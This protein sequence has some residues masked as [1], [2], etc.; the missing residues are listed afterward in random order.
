MTMWFE[1]E[2]VITPLDAFATLP[3]WLRA[4]MDGPRIQRSL[5]QAV[6]ELTAG[7]LQLRSCTPQRL[8]AKDDQWLA[9]YQLDIATSGGETKDIVLVGNLYAPAVTAPAVPA[10]DVNAPFG[11]AGW[12]C[13][14]PDL[15]LL[16]RVEGADPALPALRDILDPSAAADLLQKVLIDAGYGSA[17]VASCRPDPVRYKPGSRCTVVVG[18]TYADSDGALPGPDPIVI[19]THQGDKGQT[20]WTAMTALWESPLREGDALT[21]AEPLAYDAERRLLFQGPIPE[22]QTLKVLVRDAITDGTPAALQLLREELA[23]TGRGLAALHHCGAS[24]GRTAT[25][26]EEV[27]EI[28]EVVSRLSVSVPQLQVAADPLLDR[29]D[30]LSAAFPAEQ[31]VPA[32]HDFRPA[33]VLLHAGSIGFIDFDGASMAEPALDLGRFRAKL[34]DIGISTLAY[35]EKPLT[36][37]PLSENLTLLDDLCDVFLDAYRELAP[38]STE[39]VLL[40]E[41]CDL[42]TGMLHAWTKVRLARID[43]RLT[44]LRHHLTAVN[45]LAE[46]R[47]VAEGEPSRRLEAGAVL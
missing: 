20:A 31:S 14:L 18:V 41:T 38:V 39:R 9:R 42:L 15:R 24:Y 28:R 26:D 33:Q 16:L 10:P 36:G 40:W 1:T 25:L 29:L 19:K 2:E 13:W 8:R 4:G 23:K 5:E 44:L 22:D 17:V 37:P 21:I 12:A 7:S 32:H 47:G 45:H 3:D 30:E 6:P 46:Q 35:S 27:L 11:E 34:R 43:P